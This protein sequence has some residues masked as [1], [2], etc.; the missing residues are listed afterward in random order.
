M[1]FR[2]KVNMRS[3]SLL[4][5]T[6]SI[7]IMAGCK[8]GD[9]VVETR[10][11]QAF[12]IKP[13]DIIV[14]SQTSD[15]LVQLDSDGNFK[16][17]LHTLPVATDSIHSVAFK[18]DTKEIIFTINGTAR[19]GAISVVDGA[20]RTFILNVNLTGALR[21]LAQLPGGD[22]LIAEAN[23]VERFSS[24]GVR[25][26]LV[27]GVTWPNTLGATAA[28]EQIHIAANG[29]IIVCGSANVNRFTQN[30]VR[31]GAAVVS[32]IA[33]TTT[34]TGCIEMTNGSIA[35]AFSGTTDTYRSVA[36]TMLQASIATIYSDLAYLSTP[37]WLTQ[38]LSGNLLSADSALN[39]IVEFTPTGS[40][41]RTLGGSVVVAPNAV[42]S[43]PNY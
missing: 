11:S 24:E 41:V 33:A 25:R 5:I 36:S 27:S 31:V 21:G 30:A 8:P 20:F 37:R 14:T 32:A 12:L 13:G 15:S 3:W 16:S 26:T 34:A 29:D 1:F 38:N 35:T 39:Q 17:I 7:L 42:F 9:P 2:K 6:L 23:N 10:S 4:F 28:P 18:S 22:I 43:V 40:F 19:V